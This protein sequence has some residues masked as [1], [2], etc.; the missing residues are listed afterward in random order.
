MSVTDERT[1][2]GNAGVYDALIIG[3]TANEEK[4]LLQSSPKGIISAR[5]ENFTINGA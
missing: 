4:K 2:D 1:G 5:S 3:R